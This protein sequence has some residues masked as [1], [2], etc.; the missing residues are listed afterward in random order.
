[1]SRSLD[2]SVKGKKF[3][4]FVSGAVAKSSYQFL[5]ENESR[6][7][8]DLN[9][10]KQNKDGNLLMNEYCDLVTS[11]DTDS[12]SSSITNTF[13]VPKS[14]GAIA[15]RM[16]KYIFTVIMHLTPKH[17]R[18]ST[19]LQCKKYCQVCYSAL[20]QVL[21][22]IVLWNEGHYCT[23]VNRANNI[24]TIMHVQGCYMS[25][26]SYILSKYRKG[27]PQER[28]T[29]ITPKMAHFL[30]CNKTTNILIVARLFF[31]EVYRLHS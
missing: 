12:V 30:A 19:T 4:G 24:L 13:G 22:V 31:K 16:K 3:V 18:R 7:T 20:L 25:I 27:K 11:D 6:L 14:G 21:L 28:Y 9:N 26:Y 29:K 10:A 15:S 8:L 2:C 17:N 1:M 5:I 23:F